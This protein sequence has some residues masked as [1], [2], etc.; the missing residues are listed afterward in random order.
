MPQRG[1]MRVNIWVRAGCRPLKTPSTN[2]ELAESGADADRTVGAVDADV[3]VLAERVVAP[4]DIAE[5]LVVEAVVRRV[6][7]PLLLP[8]APRVRAGRGEGDP[9][10]LG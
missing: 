5:H 9:A 1:N 3:D 7:D 6:D 10:W 8:R 4:D 2:G